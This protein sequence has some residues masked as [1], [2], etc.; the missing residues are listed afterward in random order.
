MA[1]FS[2]SFW[3]SNLD[4]PTSSQQIELERWDWSHLKELLK[5]FMNPI[6][7]KIETVLIFLIHRDEYNL[8]NGGY[9]AHF[10]MGQ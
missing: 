9:F 10:Y 1:I 8:E 2:I 4:L 5:Y 6:W 7:K 3:A